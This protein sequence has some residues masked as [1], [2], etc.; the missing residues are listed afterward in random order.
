MLPPDLLAMDL[1]KKLRFDPHA[2]NLASTDFGN[3]TRALPAAVLYPSSQNDIATLIHSSYS[4]HLPFPIAAK[5]HGHSIHGQAMAYK[6]VV[7]EMGSLDG[8][9]GTRINVSSTPPY[10]F[11]DVGGEQLWIDV[12]HA[13]LRHGLAPLSW[14]DYLYLTVGGTLSNAGISGQAFRHGPQISNVYEMDVVTGTF[15]K[16]LH[17]CLSWLSVSYLHSSISFYIYIYVLHVCGYGVSNHACMHARVGTGKGEV[18]KCSRQLN[19]ELY[20][21]VLGGLGQFGIITRARIALEPAPQRVWNQH[22]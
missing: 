8:K 17:L 13:T 21:A 4:S 11:A 20:Y 3:L 14:T 19:S 1:A 16:F 2:T 12:L 15:L 6:G 18:V 22:F 9:D 7:I 10:F 5:G